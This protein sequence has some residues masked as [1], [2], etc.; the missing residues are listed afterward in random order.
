MSRQDL[1]NA[2]A[3]SKKGYGQPG[4][5]SNYPKN[6]DIE[7]LLTSSETVEYALKCQSGFQMAIALLTSERVVISSKA[8]MGK[9]FGHGNESITFD[10]ITGIE[11]E[12]VFAQGFSLTISRADNTDTLTYCN[13]EDGQTFVNALRDK[14]QTSST[15]SRTK[16]DP[17]D[18]I[19]KLKELL[20][21]GALTQE[22]FD[23][24][25]K[26]ILG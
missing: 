4:F 7:K 16:Q 8:N 24:E 15:P 26:K 5:M 10:K 25:K 21:A 22:E 19:K 18:Q 23:L 20:D 2:I 12:K 9:A 13:A 11:G 6:E 14:V 17:L 1:D 3:N